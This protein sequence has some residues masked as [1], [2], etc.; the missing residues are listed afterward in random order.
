MRWL[1][2]D[3][4]EMRFDDQELDPIR[5]FTAALELRG[6]V[7]PT[8]QR[9]TDILLRGQDLAFLPA[10]AEVAPENWVQV[11]PSDILI[12]VPPPLPKRASVKIRTTQQDVFVKLDRYR[13]TGRAHFR[14]DDTLDDA[15]RHRQPFL[16]LTKAKLEG[17]E[18][19][20]AIDV[21]IVNLGA[22]TEFGFVPKG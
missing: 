21:A 3:R 9:I 19:P 14:P 18:K 13:V 15:F 2:S 10:G 11:S 22:A 17:G 1:R 6:F 8:G 16:A 20:D 7:A 5:I 4:R 12:V